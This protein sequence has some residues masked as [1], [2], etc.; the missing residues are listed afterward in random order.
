MGDGPPARS[1]ASCWAVAAGGLL[2]LLL[3]A[4]PAVSRISPALQ[5][6]SFVAVVSVLPFVLLA[7]LVRFRLMDVDLYVARTLARGAVVVLVLLL[8]A[9]VADRAGDA[10]G[11]A[12]AALVVL[13]AL[14]GMPLVRALERIVDR[15][16]SGG[17]VRGHELLR[18]LSDELIAPTRGDQARRTAETVRASMDAS[19]VRLT[20]EGLDVMA[21]SPVEAATDVV[22]P[23]LAG[24]AEVGRLECGPRHG[25]W[26][27][28]E[29]AEVA[30]LGRHAGLALHNSELTDRLAR[31]VVEL[32]AS[33]L[34]S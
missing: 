18:R 26:G 1:V 14:T 7:G 25:G 11:V 32:E 28:A 34:A 23:L 16:L 13:A 30:L 4:S 6:W 2:A 20:V 31:Q 21:G 15:W 9:F 10:E 27:S 19:W 22:V 33:R 8:Y 29:I 24:E 5:T 3:L 12:A 17:R